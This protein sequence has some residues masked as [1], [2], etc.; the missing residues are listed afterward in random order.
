M[1]VASTTDVADAVAVETGVEVMTNVKVMTDVEVGSITVEVVEEVTSTFR[2][3][4]CLWVTFTV[5]VTVLCIVEVCTAE[6]T[7]V[8]EAM[9]PN[10]TMSV[11][12]VSFLP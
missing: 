3:A 4:S 11:G 10:G 5:E 6:A 1:E 7:L 9:S 2:V 8:G 12:K